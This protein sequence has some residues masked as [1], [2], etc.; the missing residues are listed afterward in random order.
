[1]SGYLFQLANGGVRQFPTVNRCSVTLDFVGFATHFA[2]VF[3]APLFSGCANVRPAY[4]M[5]VGGRC[6][7]SAIVH[8]YFQV[9]LLSVSRLWPRKSTTEKD[10]RV[11][12]ACCVRCYVC[13]RCGACNRSS[14]T[15]D[16]CACSITG[17]TYSR[18][19]LDS[20][21]LSWTSRKSCSG[22][23]SRWV[24]LLSVCLIYLSFLLYTREE[25]PAELAPTLAGLID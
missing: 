17:A 18:A 24:Y 10:Q 15:C 1:M 20:C 8:K 11:Y 2:F 16:T 7:T 13:V 5:Y 14:S 12:L 21:R 19:P 6:S 22:I 9:Q 3:T 4:I 23:C 25:R